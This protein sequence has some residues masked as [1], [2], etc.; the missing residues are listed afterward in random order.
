MIAAKD[1]GVRPSNG[2]VASSVGSASTNGTKTLS[3][4][5]VPVAGSCV[6]GANGEYMQ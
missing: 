1:C 4:R 2:N 3:Q 6:P 5:T